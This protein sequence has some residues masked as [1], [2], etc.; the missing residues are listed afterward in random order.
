MQEQ[1]QRNTLFFRI[2]NI[3]QNLIM[4]CSLSYKAT[5]GRTTKLRK[6]LLAKKICYYSLRPEEL[7]SFS[8]VSMSY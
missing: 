5:S 6:I 1:K 3:S 7:A 4:V 2:L 8:I